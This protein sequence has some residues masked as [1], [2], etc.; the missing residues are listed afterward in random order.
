MCVSIPQEMVLWTGTGKA[1]SF[2]AYSKGFF[3]PLINIREE[4]DNL[5][6]TLQIRK[7]LNEQEIEWVATLLIT[8]QLICL[9]YQAS[10]N[11]VNLGYA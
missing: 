3:L 7:D 10:I 8:R 9:F 4:Q 5:F 6:A 1:I 2:G 11:P